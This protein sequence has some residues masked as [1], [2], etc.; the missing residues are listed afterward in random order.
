MKKTLGILSIFFSTCVNFTAFSDELTDST[1]QQFFSESHALVSQIKELFSDGI[2]VEDIVKTYQIID[3][4]I[5]E[6]PK[7]TLQEK[8]AFATNI[9]CEV[10]DL[11]NIPYMP[12]VISETVVYMCAPIVSQLVYPEEDSLTCL[13][14]LAGVPHQADIKSSV[15]SFIAEFSDGLTLQELPTCFMY[16]TAFANSCKDLDSHNKANVAKFVITQL[17]DKTDMQL[18][19]DFLFDE[20]FK[21][22]GFSLVDYFSARGYL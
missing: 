10:G 17:L 13:D 12:H 4:F 9:L 15:D 1:Q 16:A 2:S 18:L 3:K 21:T 14:P 7:M 19:P 5:D 8:R 11:I 22:L 6:K 20:F